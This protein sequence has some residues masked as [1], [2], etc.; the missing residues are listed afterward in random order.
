MNFIDAHDFSV[1]LVLRVQQVITR[2]NWAVGVMT[3]HPARRKPHRR[4]DL[5]AVLTTL[6]AR[7]QAAARVVNRIEDTTLRSSG[8]A[9]PVQRDRE[10]NQDMPTGFDTEEIMSAGGS[11][12]RGRAAVVDVVDT[13]SAVIAGSSTAQSAIPSRTRQAGVVTPQGHRQSLFG[14]GRRQ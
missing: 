6:A 4:T 12:T 1:G 11:A 10:G 7:S 13:G 9:A 2:V 14:P 3:I 5:G 8:P